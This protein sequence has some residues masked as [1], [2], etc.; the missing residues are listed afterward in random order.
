MDRA[1]QRVRVAFAVV[2]PW[3]LAFCEPTVM[4]VTTELGIA[5]GVDGANDSSNG[6]NG[7]IRGG[8]GDD[9]IEDTGD[10]GD[11]MMRKKSRFHNNWSYALTAVR[12]AAEEQRNEAEYTKALTCQQQA[13]SLS[14]GALLG[15]LRVGSNPY[16]HKD[17]KR[18]EEKRR[19]EKP[20]C[21]LRSVW[22]VVCNLCGVVCAIRVLLQR[23]NM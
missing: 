21:A 4:E 6:S 7:S 10:A 3:L 19:E 22:G 14:L 15:A 9:T 5:R 23:T 1:R 17:E 18:R 13:R 16:V 2:G 12:E 8:D 20:C 11:V